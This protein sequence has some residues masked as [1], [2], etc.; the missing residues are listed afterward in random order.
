MQ[1]FLGSDMPPLKC[2]T[3]THLRFQFKLHI[4]VHNEKHVA[5]DPLCFLLIHLF[6][7]FTWGGG[8]LNANFVQQLFQLRKHQLDILPIFYFQN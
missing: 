3:H 4:D 1:M 5:S 8:G 2:L 7:I 6:L